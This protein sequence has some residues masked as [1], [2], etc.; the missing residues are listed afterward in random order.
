MYLVHCKL[1]IKVFLL[2]EKESMADVYY[3]DRVKNPLKQAI[4]HILIFRDGLSP[5]ACILISADSDLYLQNN[6]YSSPM[7]F[8]KVTDL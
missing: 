5:R 7:D 4:P 8:L 1:V 6:K 2:W 3:N